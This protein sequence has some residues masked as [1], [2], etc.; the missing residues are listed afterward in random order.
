[1]A[2]TGNAPAPSESYFKAS[3]IVSRALNSPLPTTGLTLRVFA[4]PFKDAAPN[5][6]VVM[7]IELRGRDLALDA[8]RQVEWSYVVVDAS[9]RVRTGD[10]S[11]FTLKLAPEMKARVQSQGLRLLN[12]VSLPP[13]RYQFRVAV[14]DEG[15]DALGAVNYH[16][17]IP[18]FHKAP[19]G[20]SGVLL[21]SKAGVATMTARADPQLQKMMPAP[22]VGLRAFPQNDELMAFVEVYDRGGATA[23]TVDIVTTVKSDAGTV[24][25]EHDDE[26]SSSE[27]QG[28]SGGYGHLVRIP[29][30]EFSPGHYVLTVEARSRLGQTATRQV[31]FDV[32]A[33]AP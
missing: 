23:H 2:P 5:A 15:N 3:P 32:T 8:N 29:M 17:E 1:V 24:V 27:L 31:G 12:R 4:A 14:H 22:P 28:A 13:G 16:L 21:S 33:A 6:S 20:M 11:R 30:N 19:F 25:F 7:G 18:D 26:R 10:T 9:G